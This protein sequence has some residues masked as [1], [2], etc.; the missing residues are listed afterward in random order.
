[1][2]A[3]WKARE[4]GSSSVGPCEKEEVSVVVREAYTAPPAKSVK[5]DDPF[6]AAAVAAVPPTPTS[7]T[8]LPSPIGPA[9]LD[10]IRSIYRDAFGPAIDDFFETSWYA[11][12]GLARLLADPRLCS[13]FAS[14]LERSR[15][16]F[17]DDPASLTGTQSLETALIWSLMGLC[18][19]AAAG[20]TLDRSSSSAVE[21][22]APEGSAPALGHVPEEEGLI[23]AVQR[24]DILEHLVSGPGTAGLL[25][26]NV[27]AW[28]EPTDGGPEGFWTLA[29]RFARLPEG[30][31]STARREALRSMR[32][33]L[34]NRENRD[35][36]YSM[37]VVRQLRSSASNFPADVSE[38]SGE[39][40]HDPAT[41]LFVAKTFLEREMTMGAHRVFQRLC[42]MVV[43]SW[44]G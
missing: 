2:A 26:E 5:V 21:L 44:T 24:F 15:L 12:R 40:E 29:R 23:D 38:P 16:G 4:L 3:G 32:M 6:A 39:G 9:V 17:P 19:A 1:M 33:V 25:T 13:R 42:S 43:R 27:S 8:E 41:Q 7:S 30:E 11:T 20:T 22:A 14:Y 28:T 34:E 36:V 31:S 18:R 10:D 35:I 37:A